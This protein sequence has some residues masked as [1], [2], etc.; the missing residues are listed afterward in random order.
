MKLSKNFLLILS[1]FVSISGLVL[2]YFASLNIEP[3]KIAIR[4]ITADME[5]RRIITTG[6]LAEKRKHEDGHLF[7]TISDDKTKIQIPLFADFM[8]SL[9]Q[10][11]IT[12]D[13]F[14]LNDKI[15]VRGMLENYKGKLQIIPKN[16]NDVKILGE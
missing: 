15:S 16:L 13:D 3:Q 4:D 2:I 1:L 5:G 11:G 9:E 7:L 14:H 6:Y 8:K 12:A 10:A